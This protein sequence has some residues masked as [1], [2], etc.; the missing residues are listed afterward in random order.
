MGIRR[1]DEMKK[2][3]TFKK[4][5]NKNLFKH[6]SYAIILTAVV[7]AVTIAFNTTFALLAERVNLDIDLTLTRDN[8]LDVENVEFLKGIDKEVKIT[9]CASKEDYVGGYMNYYAQNYFMTTDK[10]G[11][12][13]EQ[14]VT[15]LDLYSVYSDKIT[16]EYV[17]P[18]TPEFADI[19]SK[20]SGANLIYGDMIVECTH[21]IDGQEVVRNSFVSFEDIYYSYDSS[22]MAA[23]GYDYYYVEA[24][25]FE[26]AMTGAIYKVVSEETYK[27][28]YVSTHCDLSYA[29]NLTSTLKLNN[30]EVTEI[31]DKII[32][33]IDDELDLL[34]IM[35]P[36]EDFIAEELV[37]IND[38]L[39]GDGSRGKGV[40]FFPSAYSPE[41]PKLKG[42]L[43]EWGILYD[44]GI[45]FETN[46]D[47]Y[48][49]GD[50]THIFSKVKD[51]EEEEIAKFIEGSD[52]FISKM[53]VPM[54][55]AFEYNGGNRYTDV[56][57]Q[58]I[59]KSAVIASKDVEKTWVPDNTYVKDQFATVILAQDTL[60]VDSV[61]KTSYIAAFASTDFIASAYINDSSISNMKLTLATAK[62][63][64]GQND[65]PIEFSMKYFDTA[66]FSAT[67]T[68]SA[69]KAIKTIFVVVLPLLVVALG[70][71]VFVK[72]RTR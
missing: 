1:S 29:T 61:P 62:Q 49:T 21:L 9:V 38:W 37:A 64:V 41:T 13:Y 60:Y 68:E 23:S 16:V 59:D 10:T 32:S 46:H 48:Y 15:L 65:S 34:V 14:T 25:M 55:T 22:G 19:Y 17:D 69:T 6:G 57:A 7:I 47:N 50:P 72:R 31:K 26:T 27:V 67:V 56:L 53:N 5:K 40:L 36:K 4:P 45:V 71:F 8:S 2:N 52:Y 51:T 33:K 66:D 20:Y 63:S 70:I 42:F 58:T 54:K 18:Q 12:Y 28:G 30:F 43:Q 24:N 11:K 35:A 3:N 39:I 44:D